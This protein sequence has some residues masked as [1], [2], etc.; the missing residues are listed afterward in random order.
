MCYMVNDRA[1]V[2]S[3]N[4]L[5]VLSWADPTSTVHVLYLIN[6]TY[7]ELMACTYENSVKSEYTY[8]CTRP[9][10]ER[11]VYMYVHRRVYYYSRYVCTY[12][13]HR[14]R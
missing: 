11:H 1:N 6:P 8:V 4:T 9:S 3:R 10:V 7:V 2:A 12:A 14:I 13:K 5:H